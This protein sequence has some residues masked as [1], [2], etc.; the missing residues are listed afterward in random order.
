MKIYIAKS[1]QD[2]E[3]CYS[4]MVQLR[5]SLS[6]DEFVKRVNRQKKDG[7][8]LAFIKDNNNVMSV[9]GFRILDNLAHGKFMYIDDFVTDSENRSKGYGDKLFDFL[10]DYA[11]KE[12][13]KA[14]HLDSGVQRFDA[15]RFY[16]RKRMTIASHHFS[17]PTIK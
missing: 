2:I 15:H 8:M 11:K 16:F 7:Y 4:V 17:L 13:C 12:K 10:I 6:K 3:D 14:V 9:A 5:T 1:I